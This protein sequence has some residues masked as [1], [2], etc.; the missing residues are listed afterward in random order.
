MDY[1]YNPGNIHMENMEAIGRGMAIMIMAIWD[2]MAIM[3]MAIWVDM[4]MN[5]TMITGYGDMAIAADMIMITIG[6]RIWTPPSDE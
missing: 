5:M 4:E 3:I 2:D 6:W 1:D